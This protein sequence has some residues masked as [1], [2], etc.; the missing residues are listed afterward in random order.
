VDQAHIDHLSTTRTDD[1]IAADYAEFR[2]RCKELCEAEI[3]KDPTLRIVRGHV[4]IMAWMSD[5]R[6][7]HWWCV[8]D[9]G[10]IFDPSWRQFPSK[11]PT[12]AYEEFD[13]RVSCSNC[14]QEGDES[15]FSFE[16][17]YAFCSNHCYGRFVGVY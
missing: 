10:S 9:D 3:A 16:S 7:P 2:G 14:G 15:D 4:F 8:R 12:T 11:P 1:Q 6:Q 5:P 17:N 13:G